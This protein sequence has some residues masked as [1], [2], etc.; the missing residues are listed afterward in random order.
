M[1]VPHSCSKMFTHYPQHQHVIVSVSFC[2]VH[3]YTHTHT[4]KFTQHHLNNIIV[5]LLLTFSCLFNDGVMQICWKAQAIKFFVSDYLMS[6]AFQI[7][8]YVEF[9][10][11]QNHKIWH[12]QNLIF[13]SLRTLTEYCQP[14]KP[15]LILYYHW[16]RT[17]PFKYDV[18]NY[19]YTQIAEIYADVSLIEKQS[20]N[21][22][23]AN[24]SSQTQK[25]SYIWGKHEQ[26]KTVCIKKVT[27]NY[28]SGNAHNQSHR[29]SS[30][31]LCYFTR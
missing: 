3:I 15:Q 23:M 6:T 11:P 2:G 7:K 30:L 25:N 18:F 5:L 31:P 29:I 27:S 19:K 20:H 4:H 1:I 21:M 8:Q 26:I 24:K 9:I 14:N 22:K 12:I 17:F 28:N 10:W 16:N 13:I